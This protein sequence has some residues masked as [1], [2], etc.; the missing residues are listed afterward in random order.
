M[1]VFIPEG[2]DLG[3]LD[4]ATV[5]DEGDLHCPEALGGLL[6]L[7]GESLRVLSIAS[8]DLDGPRCPAAITQE[9][10]DNL[11]S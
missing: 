4:P 10:D 8:K 2:L 5:T 6:D 9:P 3:T 1:K 7:R 11:A